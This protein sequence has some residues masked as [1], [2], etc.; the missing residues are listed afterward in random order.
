MLVAGCE[1]AGLQGLEEAGH[2]P[3]GGGVVVMDPGLLEDMTPGH[4]RHRHQ[5]D[6]ASCQNIDGQHCSGQVIRSETVNKM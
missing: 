1:G 2:F 4:W 3:A 6:N 5:E